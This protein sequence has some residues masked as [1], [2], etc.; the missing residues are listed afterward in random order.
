MIT[1]SPRHFA[2]PASQ[3]KVTQKTAED[4]PNGVGFPVKT[5]VTLPVCHKSQH[6]TQ[7]AG[8]YDGFFESQP[9]AVRTGCNANTCTTGCAEECC[10]CDCAY[11]NLRCTIP[12]FPIKSGVTLPDCTKFEDCTQAAGDYDGFFESQPGAVR[13]G[14]N[15]ATCTTGCAEECCECDC[16]YG[17]LNCAL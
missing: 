12:E 9:G 17:N 5:G 7:A 1:L 4:G 3:P 8:D 16:R 6:C 15:A 2:L 13:T 14:C 11:G 10:E